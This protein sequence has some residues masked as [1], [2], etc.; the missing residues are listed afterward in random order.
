MIQ[1][2]NLTFKEL[3]KNLAREAFACGITILN[4]YLR[5]FARQNHERGI[6][7]T[8][9]ATHASAPKK[10]LGYYSVSSGQIE[11]DD[12]P[13]NVKKN[14]PRYPVPITRI[15]RLAVDHKAKGHGVGQALL[16]DALRRSL[17]ASEKIGIYG[18]I[19]DAKDEAAKSFYKK[20]GFIEL[21]DKPMVL[22][23]HMRTVKDSVS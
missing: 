6:G 15:G 18:V 22:F 11:F 8:I 7:L 13:S 4:D 3:S 17:D 16:A 19:V 9:V 21:K 5:K 20:Y 1:T 10:I 12:L 2:L 23:L 14:I